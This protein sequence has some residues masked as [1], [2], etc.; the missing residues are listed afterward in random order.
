MNRTLFV[1]IWLTA[2]LAGGCGNGG[3]GP[4]DWRPAE[5]SDPSVRLA[6]QVEDRLGEMTS[7]YRQNLKLERR[8]AQASAAQGLATP[9]A[10]ETGTFVTHE[11]ESYLTQVDSALLNRIERMKAKQ[12]ELKRTLEAQS[13]R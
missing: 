7:V 2:I 6:R 1:A 9:T 5:A 8:I 11:H 10:F 3:A 13:R 4:F 12:E